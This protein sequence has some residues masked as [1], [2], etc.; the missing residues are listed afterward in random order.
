[1]KLSPVSRLIYQLRNRLTA[2]KI[3]GRKNVSQHEKLRF[4]NEYS[5]ISNLQIRNTLE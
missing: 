4:I 2:E 5:K 1:M 3:L